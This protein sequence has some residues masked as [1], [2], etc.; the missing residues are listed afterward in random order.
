MADS[1]NFLSFDLS[2]FYQADERLAFGLLIQDI[3]RPQF[4][5]GV[6]RVLYP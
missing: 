6:K 4:M 2:L 3:N 5:I 1:A